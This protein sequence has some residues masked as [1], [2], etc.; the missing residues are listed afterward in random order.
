MRSGVVLLGDEFSS[1]PGNTKI[2]IKNF[3]S[4]NDA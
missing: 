4:G 1:I 2:I 3:T